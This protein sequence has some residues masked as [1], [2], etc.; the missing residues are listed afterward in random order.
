MSGEAIRLVIK[1]RRRLVRD[2]ICA[3][4]AGRPDFTVVGHT[5]TMDAL[6][7]LCVLRRPDAVLVDTLELTVAGV[8]S[9]RRVRDAVP[10]AEVV[11]TYAEVSQRALEAAV[12]AGITALIP[13]SRGLDVVLGTIRDRASANGLP[14]PDGVAL[15]EYDMEIMSLMSSGHSVPEMAHLL[16]ISP[17]TVENHKRRLYVKLGVGSSSQAV[18]RA[19]SLGLIDAHRSNGRVRAGEPGR[20]PIVVVHGSD[21]PPLRRVQLALMAAGIPVVHSRLARTVE[22]EHW[23]RWHRGPVVAVLVDPA[24]ED[25]L[26]ASSL[27]AYPVAVLS[28]EPDLATLSDTLLRGAR[29]LVR[30]DDVAS[31][32]VPVLSVV[33]RGYLAVDAVRMEELVGGMAVRLA[34]GAGQTPTLTPREWDILG[35]IG[36]GHTIRQTAR[37][38]GITAKTVEN[39][40]AR[41][42][43]KL[44]A[45]NRVE[46]L[47]IAHRWGLLD[48]E[49]AVAAMPVGPPPQRSIGGNAPPGGFPSPQG[50]SVP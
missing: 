12:R 39:A 48:P 24:Y 32:L 28:A 49:H 40:Q 50:A 46:A 23:A 17:R 9:L 35:L 38:L 20:S 44:G 8:E 30:V 31:D 34:D 11:V 45:R 36:S 5:G 14:Q 27:G 15:T 16:Q 4:L 33:V 26:A 18:S 21:G 7:E 42:Y 1:S 37:A 13:C 6:A 22:Q 29:A 43:R 3:Y 2:A 19:T 41:L 47:T 10:S 25:W